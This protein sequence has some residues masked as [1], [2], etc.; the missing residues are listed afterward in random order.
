MRLPPLV[1]L[2]ALVP[3]L[4]AAQEIS[5]DALLALLIAQRD[6]VAEAQ[7]VGGRTRAI[8]LLT[9]ADLVG[10]EG[11]A[12]EVMPEAIGPIADASAPE[13]PPGAETGSAP[14]ATEG[15]GGVVVASGAGGQ[16]GGLVA[17]AADQP[18]AADP[19]AVYANFAE[20]LQINVR[21][22]F[23]Y[24]SASLRDDQIP[25]LEQMCRVMP[26]TGIGAFRIIGHT[27][28]AGSD[29]Y[30]ERLSLLRAEEVRRW[31][32]ESCGLPAESLEAVGMGKRFPLDPA[33]PLAPSNRRVEFQALS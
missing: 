10:L 28:A 7:D 32:V 25:K 24:D 9:G 31:F 2:A 22:A 33:D 1:L 15:T 26:R 23:D 12:P 30:N 3:A 13:A 18:A 14:G 17:P 29:A 21:V 20:D 16:P 5:D 6:A 4:A 11:G 27:D 19:P 8:T